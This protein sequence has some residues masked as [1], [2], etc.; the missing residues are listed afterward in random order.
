VKTGLRRAA[1]AAMLTLGAVRADAQITTVVASSKRS[2]ASQQAVV[3]REQVA[4]DSIARVTLTGMTQWVDS[5]AAALAIRPDTGSAPAT[6]GAAAARPIQGGKPKVTAAAQ[7][8][9]QAPAQAPEFRDG[10]RAPDTATAIPT[11]ALTGGIML[12]IGFAVRR[13]PTPSTMRRR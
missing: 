9:T 8:S 12:L 7:P 4:Q 1:L 13:R 3:R 6:Y 2:A 11:I 10:A 5:A